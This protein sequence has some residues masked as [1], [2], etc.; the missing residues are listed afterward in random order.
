VNNHQV[1]ETLGKHPKHSIHRV[2]DTP[3]FNRWRTFAFQ[4]PGLKDRTFIQFRQDLLNLLYEDWK[5][6]QAESVEGA[7]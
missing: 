4:D 5:R 6:Y 2:A 3:L 1:L 7:T